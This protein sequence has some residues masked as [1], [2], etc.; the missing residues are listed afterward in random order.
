M[1]T[2][3]FSSPMLTLGVQSFFWSCN[4]FFFIQHSSLGIH[5]A[6]PRYGS[7]SSHCVPWLKMVLLRN[8]AGFWKKSLENE[9]WAWTTQKPG[10]SRH[11]T[12]LCQIR[13]S[14]LSASLRPPQI[15]ISDRNLCHSQ[16]AI[17]QALRLQTYSCLLP[18]INPSS[19]DPW[20]T[21]D[22]DVCRFFF[23]IYRWCP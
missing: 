12:D 13:L 2:S 21:I 11:L 14:L 10:P 18:F 5:C 17:S 8:F 19:V 20:T 4:H 9:S 15:E 3:S 22:F 6:T 1:M 7:T 16:I 23:S